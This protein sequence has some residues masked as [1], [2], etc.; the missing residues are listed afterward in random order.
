MT[1]PVVPPVEIRG[2]RYVEMPHEFAYVA[3]RGLNQKVVMIL[4]KNIA[5]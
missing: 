1:N 4:H 2:I 5:I 3:V